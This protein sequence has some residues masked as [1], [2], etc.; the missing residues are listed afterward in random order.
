MRRRSR[1]LRRFTALALALVGLVFLLRHLAGGAALPFQEPGVGIISVRGVIAE[2]EGIVAALK[3]FRDSES[4]AAV[5]VRIDSPGGSVSPSQEIYRAILKLREAKPVIASLGNLAASGGYYIASACDPIFANPGSLTGSIGVIMTIGNVEELADWAGIGET[6]IKSGPFKD[7]ASPLRPVSDAERAIL[8]RMVDDVHGQF[9][10]AVAGARGMTETE[11]R[12]VA[13]GRLYSGAQAM[14][15]GLVDELGGFDEAVA[16]AGIAGGLDGEPRR[17][18]A[19]IGRR[20]TVRDWLGLLLGIRTD[21]LLT[22]SLPDGLH[23][24]YLGRQA[25]L[26]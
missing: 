4:V 8:Q 2:S 24:L 22:G 11:V 13:D 7:I 12:A 14:E 19:R 23:F 16:R 3:D 5:V 6:I 26:R 10:T 15:V 9:V 17:I 18:H 21:G 1:R 20:R 25:G